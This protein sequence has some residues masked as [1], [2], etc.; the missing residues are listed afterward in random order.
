MT[1]PHEQYSGARHH[2]N[3]SDRTVTAKSYQ[4]QH[5]TTNCHCNHHHDHQL[6]A[7]QLIAR[8]PLGS[9]DAAF[10]K[11]ADQ[12][13]RNASGL[14]ADANEWQTMP[15]SAAPR[16]NSHSSRIAGKMQQQ[17]QQQ[18]RPLSAPSSATTTTRTLSTA[19]TDLTSSSGFSSQ[20]PGGTLD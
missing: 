20:A 9:R 17:Q 15:T 10:L 18:Q 13:K 16:L 11:F 3:K 12:L 7:S 19:A 1:T 2:V 14:S 6:N 4:R 8:T 5:N